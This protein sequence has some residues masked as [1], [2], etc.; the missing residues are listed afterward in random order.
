[1]RVE[2][3]WM[4]AASGIERQVDNGWELACPDLRSKLD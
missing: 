2:R 4:N 1:M 3:M